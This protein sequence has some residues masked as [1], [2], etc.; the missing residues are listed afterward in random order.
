MNYGIFFFLVN[1]TF[2]LITQVFVAIKVSRYFSECL[3]GTVPTNSKYFPIKS[4]KYPIHKGQ[5]VR[6]I[7]RNYYYSS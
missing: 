5:L 4:I 3:N 7:E 2:T 6:E 1:L